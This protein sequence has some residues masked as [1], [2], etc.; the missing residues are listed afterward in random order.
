MNLQIDVLTATCVEEGGVAESEE[1]IEVVQL[2]HVVGYGM[3][4]M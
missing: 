2:I 4:V 1:G 3:E